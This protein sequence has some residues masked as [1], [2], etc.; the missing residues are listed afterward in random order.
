MDLESVDDPAVRKAA[1]HSGK[2][3]TA[4]DLGLDDPALAAAMEEAAKAQKIAFDQAAKDAM[5]TLDPALE[6]QPSGG[7][8]KSACFDS[9]PR[10]C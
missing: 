8:Q 6:K 2:K 7:A 5:K 9:P 3:A 1:L 4:K 10:A